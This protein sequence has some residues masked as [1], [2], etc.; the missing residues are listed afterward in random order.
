MRVVVW[1]NGW[2]LSDFGEE[3]SNSLLFSFPNI[4]YYA[5]SNIL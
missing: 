5:V 4:Q 3:G 1:V 2:V